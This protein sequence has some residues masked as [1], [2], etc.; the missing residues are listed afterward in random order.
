MGPAV[1]LERT[2]RAHAPGKP[3]LKHPQRASGLM[4]I[5]PNRPPD[6][7]WQEQPEGLP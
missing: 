1:R 4:T 2:Q 5:A 7:H 6:A 3:G